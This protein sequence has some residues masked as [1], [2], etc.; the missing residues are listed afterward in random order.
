MRVSLHLEI[1]ALREKVV[2]LSHIEERRYVMNYDTPEW[3]ANQ[4]SQSTNES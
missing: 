4:S 1:A 3:K 2:A